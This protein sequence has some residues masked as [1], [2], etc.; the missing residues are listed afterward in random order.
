M[1]ITHHFRSMVLPLLLGTALLTG[2]ASNPKLGSM[3]PSKA[4][5]AWLANQSLDRHLPIPVK[6]VATR[7]LRDTWGAAR[8]NGRRHEGIDIFA[9]KGTTVR[10]TT[11]GIVQRI[12]TGGAG[13][14][15]V[16]VLGPDLSRHY[17]AHLDDFGRISVGQ[18]IDQGD[19][20]GEVGNTG[21]AKGG[22]PHLHYG[23]Y[24]RNG[25]ATNP[26]P[27]LAD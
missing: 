7:E 1:P 10:S 17:Y 23:I 3:Q 5:T 6:G 26:Y 15:A 18:R 16:W 21:N 4:D 11:D 13:G 14:K 27:Y 19:K 20:I 12:R 9:K 24:L 22:R 8:S 25:Q 2:C